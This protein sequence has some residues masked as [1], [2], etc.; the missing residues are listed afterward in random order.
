MFLGVIFA[1]FA[2]LH[3]YKHA[4]AGIV[5]FVIAIAVFITVMAA[6]VI[7]TFNAPHIPAFLN[8]KNGQYG[9]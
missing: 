5:L 2:A 7:F 6:F 8:P 3:V 9:I 1:Q 4:K